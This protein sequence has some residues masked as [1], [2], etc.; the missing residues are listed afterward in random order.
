M[1]FAHI[2]DCH[3]GGWR[4]EALRKLSIDSLKKVIDVCIQENVAFLLISG[5]L[6]NTSLP[7]IDYIKEVA[8]L[9]N[10]LKEAD[11]SIY[12][13]PGSHDYS[14][15][16]KTMLEVFEHA[17]LVHN[18]MKF[19]DGKLQFTLD[20]TGTKITG[21][22]GRRSGLDALD[23]ATL[24]KEHLE[25]EKGFKIFMFHTTLEEFK[26]KDFENV[27]GTSYSSMPKT[28]QYYAGGHVHYRF[29]IAK[30][31]YGKIVYPGPVFPNNF[32][33]LEELKCGGMCIVDDKLNVRRIPLQLKEVVSLHCDV[34][35]KTAAEARAFLEESL[36]NQEVKEKIVTLR[37]SGELS[38]GKI[39]DLQLHT[40]GEHLEM[41]ALLQNTHMLS[42]KEIL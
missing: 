42:T 15:S 28:F 2:A 23:Y 17:G 5:D 29:D 22:Y 11:I 27:E 19:E 4:E 8:S 37:I 9:F 6:F 31:G 41:Y 32:K 16:G 24:Q 13:I 20:K 33:E 18:V 25:S 30:E 34:S 10:M 39:S 12:I 14:P 7:Q 40:L 36:R 21:L 1:K 38:S 26:P 3:V 35:N